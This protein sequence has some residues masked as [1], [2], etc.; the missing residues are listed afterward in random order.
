MPGL[1]GDQRAASAVAPGPARLRGPILS[2]VGDV[3]EDEQVVAGAWRSRKIGLLA[4][5]HTWG[6]TLTYHPDVQRL[7]PGGGVALD[8]KR[9]VEAN[10]TSCSPSMRCRRRSAACS[11]TAST[12]SPRKERVELLWRTDSARRTGGLECPH[13][14][15][16]QSPFV[17]QDAPSNV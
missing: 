9:W 3:V 14:R 6:Q 11:S 4:V 15:A 7:V 17:V 16:A 2:D 12:R 10:R 8:G 1:R 13:A 5:L